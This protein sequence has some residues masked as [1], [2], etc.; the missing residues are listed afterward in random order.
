M[1]MAF[2]KYSKSIFNRS[3]E[4]KCALSQIFA[5]RR[6]WQPRRLDHFHLPFTV[7]VKISR[8]NLIYNV[9]EYFYDFRHAHFN[10]VDK[11]LLIFAWLTIL[12]C[13]NVDDAEGCFYD[14]AYL[15]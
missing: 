4:W 13:L 8:N 3:F 11:F 9:K 10:D 7:C 14:F 15:P 6:C 5:V 12:T 1:F 2:S